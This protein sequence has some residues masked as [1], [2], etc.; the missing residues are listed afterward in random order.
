MTKLLAPESAKGDVHNEFKQSFNGQNGQ[1]EHDAPTNEREQENGS[2]KNDNEKEGKKM[3][4]ETKK[5]GNKNKALSAQEIRKHA[6]VWAA[7][8]EAG[9]LKDGARVSEVCNDADCNKVQAKEIIYVACE[10]AG[11]FIPRID[12]SL[13][14]A[15]ENPHVNAQKSLIIPAKTMQSIVVDNTDKMIFPEGT[16][17][18][19]EHDADT[20]ILTKI[21]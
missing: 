19:M 2:L 9:E 17:F 21:A 12:D 15:T 1:D 11:A 16:Q 20:I 7:K 5:P 13:A 8:Y 4:T 6:H 3:T 18:T 14:S 10:I